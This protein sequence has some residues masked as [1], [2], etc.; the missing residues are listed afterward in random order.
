MQKTTRR[1]H[2]NPPLSLELLKLTSRVANL[3]Q[4]KTINQIKR[5]G[6]PFVILVLLIRPEDEPYDGVC[7]PSMAGSNVSCLVGETI[8]EFLA[9]L[10]YRSWQTSQ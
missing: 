4:A 3:F 9:D 1:I 7:F 10:A 5:T 6:R 2:D 8:E